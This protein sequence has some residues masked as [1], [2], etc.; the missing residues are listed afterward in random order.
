MQPLFLKNKMTRHK[1][2]LASTYIFNVMHSKYNL[3]NAIRD[4][5][6]LILLENIEISLCLTREMNFLFKYFH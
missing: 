3:K 5:L 1:C 2:N 4:G 6:H